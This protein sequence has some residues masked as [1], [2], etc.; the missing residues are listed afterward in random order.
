MLI[1]RKNFDLYFPS[2]RFINI[3][4]KEVFFTFCVHGAVIFLGQLLFFNVLTIIS[5]WTFAL[6]AFYGLPL[7]KKIWCRLGYSNITFWILLVIYLVISAIAADIL[8]DYIAM[9]VSI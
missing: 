7:T 4:R 9:N 6:E 8:R 1:G 5:I 3:P 2:D